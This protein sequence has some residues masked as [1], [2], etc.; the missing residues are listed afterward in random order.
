MTKLPCINCITL[1]MCKSVLEANYI[2]F[3]DVKKNKK[4]T[5]YH[6]K[7][8]NYEE[9]E[10]LL[11]WLEKLMLHPILDKCSIATE[12]MIGNKELGIDSKRVTALFSYLHIKGYLEYSQLKQKRARCVQAAIR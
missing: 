4:T 3:L 1:S 9:L 10:W 12:Y 5:V 7:W 11:A 2:K 8:T 6:L